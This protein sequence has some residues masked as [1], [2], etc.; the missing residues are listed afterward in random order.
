MYARSSEMRLNG[1]WKSEGV[2]TEIPG[3]AVQVVFGI[4]VGGIFGNFEALRW[5]SREPEDGCNLTL[6][7]RLNVICLGT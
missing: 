4:S 3:D 2:F 7:E 6:L 1:F 5:V